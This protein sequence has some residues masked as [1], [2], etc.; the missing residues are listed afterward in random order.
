MKFDISRAWED[1]AGLIGRHRNA[2]A[3]IAGIFSVVPGLI[4]AYLYAGAQ[5]QATQNLQ[6]IISGQRSPPGPQASSPFDVLWWALILLL[7]HLVGYMSLFALVKDAGHTTKREALIVGLKSLPS[8]IGA[9]LVLFI[10]YIVAGALA[11]VIIGSMAG[12]NEGLGSDLP[13]LAIVLGIAIGVLYLT[14]KC[15]LALPVIAIEGVLNPATAMLRSWKLTK[16]NGLRL[17]GFYVLLTL[18]YLVVAGFVLG[19]RIAVSGTIAG[20][21]VTAQTAIGALD[22]VLGAAI[23]VVAIAIL[24][25][26]HRQL[27]GPSSASL[28]ETFQ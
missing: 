22:A 13:R 23:A 12:P 25:A 3:V 18:V 15:S 9:V 14:T 26:I 24:A 10:I 19:T 20:Q 21:S 16:G 17:F 4:T 6:A 1:A 11:G 27:S 8:A 2:M 7:V 28:A 5:A